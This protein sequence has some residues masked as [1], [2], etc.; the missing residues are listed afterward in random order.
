MKTKPRWTWGARFFVTALYLGIA[1]AIVA[2]MKASEPTIEILTPEGKYL[3]RDCTPFDTKEQRDAHD[4]MQ[5]RA[6]A[7]IAN[8]AGFGPSSPYLTID[9]KTVATVLSYPEFITLPCGVKISISDG[10]VTV[11]NGTDVGKG[12]RE[13]WKAVAQSFPEVKEAIIANDP[14]LDMFKQL[15]KSERAERDMNIE[16]M[17][18]GLYAVRELSRHTELS[19]KVFKDDKAVQEVSLFN[20]CWCAK[21]ENNINAA[22]QIE[23]INRGDKKA[24]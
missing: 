3:S 14:R 21:A 22:L 20:L 16:A 2:V 6:G 8:G 13:F 23:K 12:A 10:V 18:T 11:P 1:G 5:A 17:E 9:L 4:A 24:P 7:V 19:M 15:A